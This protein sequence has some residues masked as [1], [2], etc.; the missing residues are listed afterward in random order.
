MMEAMIWTITFTIG[1]VAFLEALT[2]HYV[3]VA[4]KEE[5]SQES[6]RQVDSRSIRYLR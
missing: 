4:G 3:F 1:S 5:R 2:N 6:K